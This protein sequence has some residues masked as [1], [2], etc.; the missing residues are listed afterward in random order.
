MTN[1]TF[2]LTGIFASMVILGS[3]IAHG[4]NAPLT[5]VGAGSACI[6]EAL[7]LPISV[8]DF[9]QITAI[10]LRLDFNP[11]L[12][13]FT[14]YANL[15]S[16]IEGCM[17]NSVSV[18]PD[19]EKIMI[20]W[21]AVT[22]L[23]LENS[24]KL[25]DLNFILN[26]GEPT[27]SFNNT[28]NGGGDCEYAD[29]VGEPLNDLPTAI[30]YIN[31]TITN[32]EAGATGSITGPI[33]ICQGQ[34]NVPYSSPAIDN[35]T[36]YLWAY[37]GTGATINGNTNNVTIDFAA[38][39]SSGSLTVTGIN[40]CGN[41]QVSEDFPITINL[42]PIVYA[43]DDQSILSGTST[44]LAGTVTS[45]SGSYS[46]HWVPVD[47]LLDPEIQNPIT[48]DL[49]TAVIFTLTVFDL[50]SCSSSDDVFINV[51]E[52]LTL[53]VNAIPDSVCSGGMVQLTA[54]PLGGNGSYSYSWSSDPVGFT[55]NLQ[56]PLAF[57][58][59]T[60][61]Y[62]V[63]VNDGTTIITD[64]VMVTVHPLPNIPEMPN[65]PDIVDLNDVDSSMYSIPN[66]PFSE[67][68]RWELIPETSGNIFGYDTIG[69]VVWNTSYM[70]N[71]TIR[72]SSVN[73][74]GQSDF[75]PGKQTFVD[76]TTMIEDSESPDFIIFPNPNEGTFTIKTSLNV[77]RV[78][79]LDAYGK[80][81]SVINSP[82]KSQLFHFNLSPGVY[83]I[84]AIMKENSFKKKIIVSGRR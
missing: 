43:G 38:N 24:S 46:W 60:T 56:N 63:I 40:A 83:T 72:V 69:T 58:D 32:L 59:E 27:I 15:N 81:I 53:N 42:L 44:T 22:P 34:L 84:H 55:S 73:D 61:L 45:G 54:L 80:V 10:S 36:S 13:D 37:S 6:N 11:T 16:S 67:S 39:S 8:N 79:L 74:C 20:V 3:C 41:G 9:T 82:F 71:A 14:G 62:T 35:A 21:S 77:T 19:L 28:D 4:Q 70:G 49:N 68:Y 29:A 26:T 51:F 52:A 5:T 2:F 30:Y 47:L 65:G 64:S 33:S 17:I 50:Y 76:N 18:S 12:L 48:I 1:A 25:V 78:I 23:S 75:S 66:I 57:L 31:T 7:A